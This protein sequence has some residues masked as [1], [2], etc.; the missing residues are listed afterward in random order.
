VFVNVPSRYLGFY[1]GKTVRHPPKVDA[2]KIELGC[3]DCFDGGKIGLS[4]SEAKC[5]L[6]H[7]MIKKEQ[8]YSY[9]F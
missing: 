2:V 1:Y 9:L 7:Y 6:A 8:I 5:V 3:G 4:Y